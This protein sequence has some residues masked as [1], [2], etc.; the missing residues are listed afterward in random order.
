MPLHQQPHGQVA[1]ISASPSDA[2]HLRLTGSAHEERQ[3]APS[4]A[5]VIS[6]A[7]HL[8][9]HNLALGRAGGCFALRFREKGELVRQTKV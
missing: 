6:F 9:E 1:K 3:D 4:P 2:S 7:S 8:S 5:L